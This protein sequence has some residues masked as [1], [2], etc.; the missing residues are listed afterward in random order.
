MKN[1]ERQSQN[2]VKAKIKAQQKEET[3]LNRVP[4]AKPTQRTVFIETAIGKEK[5]ESGRFTKAY[6]KEN[7]A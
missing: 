1:S 2:A 4:L 3:R 5:R 6:Y 7:Y